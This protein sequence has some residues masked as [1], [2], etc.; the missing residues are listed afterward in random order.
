MVESMELPTQNHLEGG[1]Y[2]VHR[3]GFPSSRQGFASPVTT[4]FPL[5]APQISCQSLWEVSPQD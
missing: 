1:R 2:H 5:D 3:L 4:G